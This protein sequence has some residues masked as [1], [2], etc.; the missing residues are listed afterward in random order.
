MHAA[1]TTGARGTARLVIKGVLMAVDIRA[2]TIKGARGLAW[3]TAE[4]ECMAI[5]ICAAT[6]KEVR[7][8]MAKVM[9]RP[10]W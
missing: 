4:G 2:T 5:D 10:H 7:G 9:E 3:T 8:D 6:I 1:T